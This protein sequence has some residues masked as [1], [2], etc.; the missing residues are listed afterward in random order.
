M[1]NVLVSL[2]VMAG[3]LAGCAQEKEGTDDEPTSAECLEQGLILNATAGPDGG[4]A[5]V[6]PP[7]EI[8]NFEDPGHHC[9]VTRQRDRVHA[10]DLTGDPWVLGQYW[11][12]SLAVDGEDRGTTR[13]VYYGDQDFS[14]EGL[15]Q[16]YMVGTPTRE[17]ALHHAIFGENPM[18][19][20]VHRI[21]Y[22]PHESGDHADMFHFPLCDGSTWTTLFYGETFTLTATEISLPDDRLGPVSGGRAFAIEGASADGGRL[23]LTYSTAAQWFTSIDLDR[24]DGGTVDMRLAS[25]GAG[26]TGDAF[27]L[28]GQ[29]EEHVVA[30]AL[31]LPVAV[32]ALGL[33]TLAEATVPRADG[34]EGPY[35][36]VGVHLVGVLNGT[37][38]ARVTLTDAAGETHYQADLTA[39]GS[40]AVVETVFEAPYMAGEW[41]LSLAG[42][43]LDAGE[44]HVVAAATFVSIYDRS[45]SV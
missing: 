14:S 35:D 43:A 3:A 21:L 37:G 15:A 27:F 26:F 24:A 1:R 45:G 30:A 5:C 13:L 40:G 19:G 44:A 4:P 33:P 41:T 18:I 23:A 11:D 28:R 17:E 29:N 42:V 36:T 38:V 34:D 32:A 22:S 39:T 2:L 9:V 31:Q 6:Q 10:P 25:I 12:F 16:H 20:R 7:F 8:R